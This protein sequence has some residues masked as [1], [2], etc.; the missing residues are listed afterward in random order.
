MLFN[1]HRLFSSLH[2]SSWHQEICSHPRVYKCLLCTSPRFTRKGAMQQ[3]C[4][5]VAPKNCTFW[6]NP[7][8]WVLLRRL[9]SVYR[10]CP[11]CT[12]AKG[13]SWAQNESWK[14]VTKSK[15]LVSHKNHGIH[16]AHLSLAWALHNRASAVTAHGLILASWFNIYRVPI[17]F[18]GRQLVAPV[19]I[20]K[21]QQQHST[22]T[23]SSKRNSMPLCNIQHWR[24]WIIL[25]TS[26]HLPVIHPYWILCKVHI[27]QR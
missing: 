7:R 26:N 12:L 8:N 24:K 14:T 27:M 2:G 6:K 22:D 18:I 1:W 21:Q 25:Q 4:R 15:G 20:Y 16:S 13:H 5:N 10:Q 17:K 9:I 23:R 3:C 11:F 19:V